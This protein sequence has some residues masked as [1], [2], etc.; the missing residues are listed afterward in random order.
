M[1]LDMFVRTT[2]RQMPQISG[3]LQSTV[4]KAVDKKMMSSYNSLKALEFN[5]NP[6]NKKPPSSLH[7]FFNKC[8]SSTSLTN[9]CTKR[10]LPISQFIVPPSWADNVY[11]TMGR[12][13][14][15]RRVR[16]VKWVRGLRQ[17]RC[18]RGVR[19]VASEAGKVCEG[20]EASEASE[21]G[22]VC[23]GC[24]ASEASE[25]GEVC[26]EKGCVGAIGCRLCKE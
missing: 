21:A 1:T 25:V 15:E 2:L 22:K 23:E 14:R 11:L 17:V 8:Y 12:E 4:G 10:K 16:R 18:V 5:P 3:G 19:R 20:C 13:R 24:E 6:K 26:V 9:T 7:I